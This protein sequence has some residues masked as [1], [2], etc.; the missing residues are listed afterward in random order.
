MIN[1]ALVLFAA[2]CFALLLAALFW[3]SRKRKPAPRPTVPSNRWPKD[4]P[5]A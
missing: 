4:W 5:N 2:I 1:D 3:P